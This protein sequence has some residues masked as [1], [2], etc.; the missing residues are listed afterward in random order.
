MLHTKRYTLS[1]TCIFHY[2]MFL[3]DCL[4]GSPFAE[5]TEHVGRDPIVGAA[6]R[7]G[8]NRPGRNSPSLDRSLS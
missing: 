6:V 4:P 2:V 7:V 1:I 5:A 8:Y 3:K